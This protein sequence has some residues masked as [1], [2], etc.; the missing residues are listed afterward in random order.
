MA[1]GETFHVK[2]FTVEGSGEFPLDMLRY[3]KCWPMRCID[4]DKIEQPLGGWSTRRVRLVTHV[5]TGQ[6]WPTIDRWRSFGWRVIE[7]DRR[8]V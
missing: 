1:R 7:T 2:H 6:S 3:D 5:R 4:V 8:R